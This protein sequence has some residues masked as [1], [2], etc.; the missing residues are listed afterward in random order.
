MSF[1]VLWRRASRPL[2]GLIVEK[3]TFFSGWS[4]LLKPQSFVYDFA[5]KRHHEVNAVTP[6]MR[7]DMVGE[8]NSEGNEF[9][10]SPHNLGYL[11]LLSLLG[12]FPSMVALKQTIADSH[13]FALNFCQVLLHFCDPFLGSPEKL[14]KI[15]HSFS[16]HSSRVAADIPLAKK[17][18]Y[19]VEALG[20]ALSLE[21]EEALKAALAMSLAE[22]DQ[23]TAPVF[24][25]ITELFFITHR[26]M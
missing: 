15:D 14:A 10:L 7:L 26:A 18:F 12:Y 5:M 6:Y 20:D 4:K 2:W 19:Q 3:M 17:E 16:M 22:G 21:E 11:S 25:F 24:N 9:Q 13:A 8:R 1:S 23:E